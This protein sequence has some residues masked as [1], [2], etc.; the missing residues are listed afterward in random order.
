MSTRRPS[1]TRSTPWPANFN[2]EKKTLVLA[3]VAA[4]LFIFLFMIC[5]FSVF[6][7]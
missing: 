7:L 6:Y 1:L 3:L 4:N 2:Q 5:L